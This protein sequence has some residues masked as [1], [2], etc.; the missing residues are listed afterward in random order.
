MALPLDNDRLA[1]ISEAASFFNTSVE[2]LRVQR[3]RDQ[4][5]GNL[6]VKVGAKL[7]FSPATIR[8]W[9][10]DQEQIQNAGTE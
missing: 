7:L 2:A 4:R 9:F 8:E 5:P 6:G 3:F 1:T 10:S